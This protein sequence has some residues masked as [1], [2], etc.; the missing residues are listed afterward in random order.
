MRSIARVMATAALGAALLAVPASQARSRLTP[1]QQ[2]AKL[3]AGRE[4]GKP[5]S[6]ISLFDTKSSK[7]IDKTAIVYGSGRTIYVNRPSNAETL[8]DDDIMVTDIRGSSQ[9]CNLDIV[10]L[11]DRGGFFYTGFVGLNDFV[12]YTRVAQAN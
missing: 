8:D 10:R 4:P 1:D 11:H 3:L 12:P 5:V 2:L 9:L 6:C 7:V